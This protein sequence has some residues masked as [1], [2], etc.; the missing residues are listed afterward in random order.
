M[1]DSCDSRPVRCVSGSGDKFN[2]SA[3]TILKKSYK[4]W[5]F[6]RSRRQVCLAKGDKAATQDEA[7]REYHRQMAGELPTTSKTTV[8]DIVAQFLAWCEK[9]RATGTAKWYAK[10]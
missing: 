2:A 5:Y 1:P 8:A 6:E 3:E 7:F 9:N 10:Y 4:A